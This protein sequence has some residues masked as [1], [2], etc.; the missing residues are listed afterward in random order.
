MFK[1][2][3]KWENKIKYTT[4]MFHNFM[5]LKYWLFQ[6]CENGHFCEI[7]DSMHIIFLEG[8]LASLGCY[9]KLS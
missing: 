6:M 2:T 4:F 7:L 9:N 1:F 5:Y 3:M 8:V